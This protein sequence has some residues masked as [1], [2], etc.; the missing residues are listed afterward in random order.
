MLAEGV[1]ITRGERGAVEPRAAATVGVS[2][3]MLL[4]FGATGQAL[5][6]CVGSY[7]SSSGSGVH[8]VPSANAGVHT[9]AST[10]SVHPNS[11]CPT[12]GTATNTHAVHF[13]TAHLN[14]AIVRLPSRGVGHSNSTQ[15]ENVHSHGV[16]P[17]P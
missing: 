8:A 14:S 12:G 3:L 1:R 7:S 6:Q 5:A 17:K 4:T 16:K 10:H 9:A 11:S 2:V 15:R 13:N